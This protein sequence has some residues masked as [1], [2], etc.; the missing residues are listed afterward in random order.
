MTQM[1]ILVHRLQHLTETLGTLRERVREAVATE[2]GK[3]VGQA[4]QDLLHL[5]A[6]PNLERSPHDIRTVDKHKP[7]DNKGVSNQRRWS[8]A[9][10]TAA[11]ILSAC[12]ARRG[13]VWVGLS[14]GLLA[15]AAAWTGGPL[16]TAGL[17][18]AAV[19]LDLLTSGAPSAPFL[20]I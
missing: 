2:F 20:T 3:A 17:S 8:A 11:H 7:I 14:L 19:T 6:R 4:V 5:L 13:T 9:T 16:L 12:S 18:L 1:P 15:G 10:Q